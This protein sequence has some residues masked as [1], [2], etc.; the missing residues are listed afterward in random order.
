MEDIFSFLKDCYKKEYS[1]IV[2]V[3]RNLNGGLFYMS[4]VKVFEESFKKILHIN[5][6]VIATNID[7]KTNEVKEDRTP[8]FNTMLNSKSFENL[9]NTEYNYDINKLRKIIRLEDRH[10]SA[11]GKR[12]RK[13]TT[14]EELNTIITLDKEKTRSIYIELYFYLVAVYTAEQGKYPSTEWNEDY[15]EH[16][17]NLDFTEISEQPDE[18]SKKS[19]SSQVKLD[20]VKQEYE[21]KLKSNETKLEK[22]TAELIEKDKAL[23]EQD[24]A[25]S[26]K[27]E[28]LLEQELLVNE[29]NEQLIQ[30]ENE[31]KKYLNEIEK[32]KSELALPKIEIKKSK[33]IT[34][35]DRKV[36]ERKSIAL[37]TNKSSSQLKNVNLVKVQE[38]SPNLSVQ[39]PL[40][41]TLSIV[42]DF[43]TNG[44]YDKAEKELLELEKDYDAGEIKLAQLCLKH[45]VDSINKLQFVKFDDSDLVSLAKIV[46]T[47]SDLTIANKLFSIIV[48]NLLEHTEVSYAL[49]LYDLILNYNFPDREKAK[50]NLLELIYAQLTQPNS[51]QDELLLTINTYAKF[52]SNSEYN[53]FIVLIIQKA[54]ENKKFKCAKSLNDT[55]LTQNKTNALLIKNDLLITLG[56]TTTH[57]IYSNLFKVDTSEKLQSYI[58]SLSTTVEQLECLNKLYTNLKLYMHTN[59]TLAQNYF[60][61]FY[62]FE[63][64]ER[65]VLKEE[66]LTELL[67]HGEV[68]EGFIDFT[69]SL[70]NLYPAEQT[71]I[72]V[73]KLAIL[74]S[75]L[76]THTNYADAKKVANLILEIDTKNSVALEVETFSDLNI[77]KSL[78]NIDFENFFDFDKYQTLLS[79]LSSERVSEVNNKLIEICLTDLVEHKNLLSLFNNLL[80][81]EKSDKQVEHY[82]S[83][84]AALFI[85][86]KRFEEATLYLNKAVAINNL[87]SRVYWQLCLCD[88]KCSTLHEAKKSKTDICDNKYYKLALVTSKKANDTAS[89]KLYTSYYTSQLA[90]R[91]R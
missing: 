13:H 28:Q 30:K 17:Y 35:K 69:L 65:E 15:F 34:I 14:L 41:D 61:K 19:K 9:L 55:L 89:Y 11:H 43:I 40:D 70:I 22:T 20:K 68:K 32:L 77:K 58:S 5:D 75:K 83:H 51:N 63:F 64:S 47:C 3:N 37:D 59:Y 72:Y 78:K 16:L 46:F 25:L 12:I 54:I 18:N 81:F 26:K 36:I 88:L 42:Y 44:W 66:I 73:S 50:E 57:E 45:K 91:E 62:D 86:A 27:Q 29:I 71:E 6:L 24:K 31:N 87:N 79:T 67:S 38:L 90:Y 48:K 4:A 10:I 8:H 82:L 76:F 23:A 39:L 33:K 21:N 49:P 53:K 1:L 52:L 2:D 84:A 74:A 7:P 80:R 60:D 56:A 85:A